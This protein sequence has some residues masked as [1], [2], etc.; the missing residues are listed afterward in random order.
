[1]SITDKNVFCECHNT[2][3]ETNFYTIA[4]VCEFDIERCK[5]ANQSHHKTVE[6]TQQYF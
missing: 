6:T 3:N 2:L 5:K 1:M 4:F